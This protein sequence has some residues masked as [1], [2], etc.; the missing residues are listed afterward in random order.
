MKLD[1][2]QL[3]EVEQFAEWFFTPQEI[4]LIMEVDETQFKKELRNP[5]S[6]VRKSFMTG[7]YRT[8]AVMRQRAIQFM[9]QGSTP[10]LS[11]T[12]KMSQRQNTALLKR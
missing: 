5:A 12:I 4:A 9:K 2:K 3:K 6:P 1:E 7:K 11:E 8:E 10:A